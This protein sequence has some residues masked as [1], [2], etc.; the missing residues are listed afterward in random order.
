MY[1]ILKM[2]QKISIIDNLY[3]IFNKYNDDKYGRL[4]L[5]KTPQSKNS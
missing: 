3:E 4:Y 2:I 1:L 5:I